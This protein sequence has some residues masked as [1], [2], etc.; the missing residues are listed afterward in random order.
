[1]EFKKKGKKITHNPDSFF[2]NLFSFLSIPF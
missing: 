1:M 2:K